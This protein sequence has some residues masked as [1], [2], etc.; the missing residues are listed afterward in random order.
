GAIADHLRRVGFPAEVEDGEDQAGVYRLVP[1]LLE[2][3]LISIIVPT[4]GARRQ[5]HGCDTDLVA[6]CVDSI[7]ARSTYENWEVVCVAGPSTPPATLDRLRD[8]TARVRAVPLR[9][10]ATLSGKINI[11]ALH[12]EGEFLVVLHDDAEVIAP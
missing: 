5:L 7:V 2:R 6:N 12:A 10:Q 3:P 9:Q 1:R 11:G 4:E 8:S